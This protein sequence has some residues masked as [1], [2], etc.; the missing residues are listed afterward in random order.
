MSAASELKALA[1]P[2]RAYELQRFFKTAKGQYGEGDNFLGLTVPQVR[3][4]ATA[5]KGLSFT[6]LSPLLSSKIHEFRLCGLII[7]NCK[8]FADA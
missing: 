1:N 6:E 3:K 7:P 2:K 8:C 5:Y 4:I